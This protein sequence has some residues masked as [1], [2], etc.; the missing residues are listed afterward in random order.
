MR[1]LTEAFAPSGRGKKGF[2]LRLKGLQDQ[3]GVL[4]DIAAAPDTAK[5]ALSNV[6][7]EAAFI[8]GSIIGERRA[9]APIRV[10][11]VKQAFAQLLKQE[12]VWG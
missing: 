8:A 1:Y 7:A 5:L 10:E 9:E 2:L 11:A 3:L 6:S 4:N 12:V